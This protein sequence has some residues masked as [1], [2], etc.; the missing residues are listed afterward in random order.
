M[1]RFWQAV[2]RA[3]QASLCLCCGVPAPGPHGESE[4]GEAHLEPCFSFEYQLEVCERKAHE[5]L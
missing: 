5:F 1:L 2:S 3:A 4:V